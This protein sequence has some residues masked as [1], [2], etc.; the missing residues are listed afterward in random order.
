MHATAGVLVYAQ[1]APGC[2]PICD[3]PMRVE[4]TV[5][6]GA[7]TL[8]HGRVSVREAVYVCARRCRE[9]GKPVRVRPAAVTASLTDRCASSERRTLVRV[10]PAQLGRWVPSG[11]V[12]GYDV[13]V[14]V[15][16]RRFVH[17]Q[18]REQI[19][20][21][22]EAEG[23]TLSLSEIS[24][25]ARR[26][27]LYLETLHGARAP[28]L[29]KALSA[30]GG[31]PLHVDATGEDGRGTLLVVY[32]GWRGWV[33]GAW[34]VPT[35]R[36][37]V[38]TPRLGQ[39][40]DLFGAP[41]A[42]MRDLGRAVT[43]AAKA[44][45][46]QRELN[47]AVLGCHMHFLRDVGRDLMQ[48]AHEQMRDAFR[49]FKVLAHL[50]ALARGL[51]RH[52]GANLRQARDGLEH[53]QRQL[54][55]D[56]RLP[57]GHAGLGCVRA[58]SQ[59][60]L[61]FPHDGL[62]QGFPFDVPQLDL[63][64]RCIEMLCA[65]DAFLRTLPSDPKVRKA[66]ERL[67]CI[68]KPVDA[69]LPFGRVARL[70]R[71]RRNLFHELRDALRLGPRPAHLSPKSQ[72][73]VSPARRAAELDQIHKAVGALTD[74]LRQ[75]R[76][77]RGTAQDM[78]RAIGVVLTH[79][80]EHGPTL[81]G[82]AIVLPNGATRLVDR[83]NNVLEGF[84][85]IIKHAERRRSG[86]ACLTHD[87]EQIPAAAALALN[88][89]HPD[90]VQILCGSLEQLPAAFAQLDARGLGPSHN[91]V[92]PDIDTVSRSLPATDRDLVRSDELFLRIHAAANSRAP[93]R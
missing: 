2:C 16:Q 50:R 86:R 24:V 39:M 55:P 38:I 3:G 17:H 22:L 69:Q 7:A 4:K 26:F 77:Q 76:S 31:W 93:R 91:V 80:D 21:E 42:I 45:V 67:H 92:P 5:V 30:D 25:L 37:D 62:D 13:M 58:L 20:G 51:G 34:K 56:Y 73:P 32:A 82:H 29:R 52:L 84:F 85:R 9:P 36:A 83:T 33:L 49:R 44:F 70:L 74:S 27:L 43:E 12:V 59:W 28:Q 88:L 47:I 72:A 18:Q 65:L 60:V 87:L 35:E 54:G 63:Y 15:G 46:A 57:G 89:T 78:R 8:Q 19:R 1:G 53:W 81:W 68:L 6:H 79:L 90:Y 14:R 11:A 23:I 61:D 40:A 48:Q 75:R 64:D 66:C 71:A 10:R 41:C